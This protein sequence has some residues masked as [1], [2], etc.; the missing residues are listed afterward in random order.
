MDPPRF[1]IPP[2]GV[3]RSLC[4]KE[5]ADAFLQGFGVWQKLMLGWLTVA[6]SKGTIG[7]R[8]A[9][10]FTD[11]LQRM[12]SIRD[13]YQLVLW[14]G[15]QVGFLSDAWDT[16]GEPAFQ[17][18]ECQLVIEA[19]TPAGVSHGTC[20]YCLLPMSDRSHAETCPVNKADA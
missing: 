4:A 10:S 7:T 19:L 2:E 18:E 12:R 1:P 11:E 9:T 20:L 8:M 6:R 17:F 14:R 16:L 5:E 13:P 3:W 15:R